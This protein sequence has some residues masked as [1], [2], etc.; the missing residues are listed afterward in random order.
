MKIIFSFLFI[1]RVLIPMH[2]TIYDNVESWEKL[3]GSEQI[4]L[5]KLKGGKVV[6]V[7]VMWTVIEE[8]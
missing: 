7:P 6:V 8:K 2:I 4:Y 5:L 3:V 1:A